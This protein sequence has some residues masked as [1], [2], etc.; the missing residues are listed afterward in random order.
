MY[1]ITYGGVQCLS[2]NNDKVVF[3][4]DYIISCRRYDDHDF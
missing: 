4:L 1:R 3:A 2:D